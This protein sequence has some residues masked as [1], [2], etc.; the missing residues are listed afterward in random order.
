MA[1]SPDIDRFVFIFHDGNLNSQA[2]AHSA[3]DSLATC[4]VDNDFE[5]FLKKLL[6]PSCH[7]IR[8]ALELIL[9]CKH[10]L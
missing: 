5:P 1:A 3:L 4:I 7:T 9:S 6:D 8:L 2:D 10:C